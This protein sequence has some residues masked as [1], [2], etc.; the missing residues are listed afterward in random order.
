VTATR[1]IDLTS[2]TLSFTSGKFG[3]GDFL[4]FSNLAV[5]SQELL[6]SQ[7]NADRMEG[8]TVTVTM[9]DGT[10]RTGA[11][12]VGDKDRENVF[13]GAGLVNASEATKDNH[14]GQSRGRGRDRD[15]DWDR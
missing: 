15:H 13:T 10:S 6:V 12:F 5:P 14:R 3:A 4:T 7:V 8:G 11:F 9:S 1:S 2:L